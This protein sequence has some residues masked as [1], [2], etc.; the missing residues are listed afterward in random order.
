[1][2]LEIYKADLKSFRLTPNILIFGSFILFFLLIFILSRIGVTIS[3]QIISKVFSII[4]GIGLLLG[5]TNFIKMK[6]I[7]GKLEG[8]IEFL[9]NIVIINGRCFPYN[10]IENVNFSIEDYKGKTQYLTRSFNAQI[11][12]GV[13]NFLSFEHSNRRKAK[14]YFQLKNSTQTSELHPFITTLIRL[15]KIHFL[16]GIEILGLT[17]YNEIQEF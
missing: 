16:R 17:D 15:Q 6:S 2:K 7:N 11:S 8:Y 14:I 10:E 13:E 1:M 9:E 12:Q 4:W 3:G 5:N